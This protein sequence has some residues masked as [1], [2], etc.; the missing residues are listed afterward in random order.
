MIL[1]PRLWIRILPFLL[2]G[3]LAR[4]KKLGDFSAQIPDWTSVVRG[5]VADQETDGPLWGSAVSLAS[6]P[7]GTRGIGTRVKGEEKPFVFRPLPP[8]VYRLT[9]TLLGYEDL[10]DTKRD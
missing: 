7:E 5:R 6:G 4:L 8:G 1:I 3:A 10:R 9:V 2:V